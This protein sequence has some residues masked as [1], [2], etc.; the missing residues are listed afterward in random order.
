MELDPQSFGG[1]Q[2]LGEVLEAKGDL[3]GAMA[4]YQAAVAVKPAFD[5]GYYNEAYVLEKMGFACRC[6]VT[7]IKSSMRWRA[8]IRMTPSTS[9]HCSKVKRAREPATN[10]LEEAGSENYLLLCAMKE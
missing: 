3:A 7:C 5:G 4:K 6:P 8:G 2:N 10:L 1:L 9:F